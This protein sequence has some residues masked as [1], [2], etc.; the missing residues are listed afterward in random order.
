M[1]RGEAVY[2]YPF[3]NEISDEFLKQVQADNT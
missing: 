3:T 1:S 2:I